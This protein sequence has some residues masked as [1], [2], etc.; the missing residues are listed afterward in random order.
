MSDISDLLVIFSI[1]QEFC[2]QKP[3]TV[4]GS[5]AKLLI[6]ELLPQV[7]LFAPVNKSGVFATVSP[8]DFYIRKPIFL[9]FDAWLAWWTNALTQ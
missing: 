1:F 3:D 8:L 2:Q 9:A 4:C 6:Y 5:T 7:C